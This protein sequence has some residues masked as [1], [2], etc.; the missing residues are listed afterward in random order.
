MSIVFASIPIYISSPCATAS[1][2]AF[3]PNQ[4]KKRSSGHHVGLQHGALEIYV[5]LRERL[6]LRVKHL[7]RHLPAVLDV[8]AAV[9]HDLRLH[10][11]HQ[12]LALADRGVS[13]PA[14]A[15]CPR[16]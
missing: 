10:D 11:G 14:C 9:G 7:L 16:C 6:E 1:L 8:V 13:V 4:K 5:V 12:A 3:R 15:P 2:H